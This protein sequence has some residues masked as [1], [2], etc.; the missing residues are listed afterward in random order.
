MFISTEDTPNPSSL[1]FTA[2]Q[3]VAGEG[4]SRDFPSADAASGVSPLAERLF[5]IGG[6]SQVFFGSDFVTVSKDDVAPWQSQKPAIM[7]VLM[8]HFTR[9]LPAITETR[10]GGL[11]KQP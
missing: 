6:V 5:A 7:G 3:P 8:E 9:S 2:G 1:K 10:Q 4:R 11:R